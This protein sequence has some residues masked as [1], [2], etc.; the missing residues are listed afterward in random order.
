V[1]NSG[2]GCVSI[3]LV[4]SAIKTETGCYSKKIINPIT[5][6]V[7]YPLNSCGWNGL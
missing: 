3:P 1:S 2:Q 4:C 6:L 7:E 5:K